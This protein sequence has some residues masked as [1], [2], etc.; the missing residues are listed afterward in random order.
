MKPILVTVMTGVVAAA[1]TAAVLIYVVP[2]HP[3]V[4]QTI[5]T[6]TTV[7]QKEPPRAPLVRQSL[8]YAPPTRTA[9]RYVPSAQAPVDYA[10]PPM[11]PRRSPYQGTVVSVRA[12]TVAAPVSPGGAILGGLAGAV[13]GH[14]IGN[15]RGQTAATV[16]GAIGGAFLGNHIGEQVSGHKVYDIVVRRDTGGR[17]RIEQHQYVAIGQRVRL[18]HGQAVPE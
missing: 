15:G 6:Q 5:A 13:V 3:H 18:S 9:P 12:V 11:A 17:V 2:V 7:T 1:A 8:G 14:Q 16:V 4:P 10:P